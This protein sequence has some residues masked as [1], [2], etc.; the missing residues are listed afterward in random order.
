[1]VFTWDKLSKLTWPKRIE[2]EANFFEN[3]L[4]VDEVENKWVFFQLLAFQQA[5]D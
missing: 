5:Q 1:M 2:D 4:R 3:M